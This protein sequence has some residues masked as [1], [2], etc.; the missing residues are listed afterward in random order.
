M[1]EKKEVQKEASFMPY[2]KAK[3]LQFFSLL[4]GLGFEV[5]AS[6]VLGRH[7]TTYDIPPAL[8]NFISWL[9]DHMV[10]MVLAANSKQIKKC[11]ILLLRAYS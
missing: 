4:A 6:H 10:A 9:T 8:F 1:E 3:Q 11:C 7:P 5:R 2:E